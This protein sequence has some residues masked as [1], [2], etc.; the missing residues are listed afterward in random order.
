MMEETNDVKFCLFATEPTQN[1]SYLLPTSFKF[2]WFFNVLVKI[3]SVLVVNN[4]EYVRQWLCV[5]ISLF[6]NY[7]AETVPA[8]TSHNFNFTTTSMTMI[9]ALSY[10]NHH[11][12]TMPKTISHILTR[13]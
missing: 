9:S 3:V 5:S 4:V 7:H 6:V 12:D 1:W 10:V 8:M 13:H 11:F 2:C